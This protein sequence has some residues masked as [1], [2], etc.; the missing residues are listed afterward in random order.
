MST[1]WPLLSVITFLPLT[2]V[3]FL[4]L[5]RETEANVATN[6]KLVAL[7]VSGLISFCLC[8]LYLGLIRPV[9]LSV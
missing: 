8:F 6:A 9:W 4:M 1:T 2:G 7:W 5:V 3:L